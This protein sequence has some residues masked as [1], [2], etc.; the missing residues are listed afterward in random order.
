MLFVFC[1]IHQTIK[2]NAAIVDV[3]CFYLH[4]ECTILEAHGLLLATMDPPPPPLSGWETVP[5]RLPC[6]T[7]GIVYSYLEGHNRVISVD[8]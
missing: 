5:Q 4:K 6:V 2:K 7:E 3:E 1:R 8:N